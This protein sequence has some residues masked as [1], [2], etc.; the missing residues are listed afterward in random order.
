MELKV[1]VSYKDLLDLIKQL[2]VNQISKLKQELNKEKFS[3]TP[4]QSFKALLL[5]GPVMDD[6]QYNAFERNR[7]HFKLWRND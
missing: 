2:P 6:L 5:Q 4:P 3:P 7:I 1:N